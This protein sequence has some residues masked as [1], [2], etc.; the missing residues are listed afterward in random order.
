MRYA[1]HISCALFA[2]LMLNACSQIKER[3][4]TVT[5][6][7]IARVYDLYLYPADIKGLTENSSKSDSSTIVNMYIHD[8]INRN[9]MIRT[10]QENLPKELLDIE[11]KVEDYRQSLIIYNYESELINQKLDTLISEEE[12]LN[13]YKKHSDN[14][15]LDEDVYQI[16]YIKVLKQTPQLDSWMKLFKSETQEDR[17]AL[18]SYCKTSAILFSLDNTKWLSSEEIMQNL[19]IGPE[20]YSKLR[21]GKNIQRV[22]NGDMVIMTKWNN[23]KQ[24]GEVSPFESVR[25]E[26]YL[27]LLNKRK[28]DLVENIYKEIYQKAQDKKD[29]EIMKPAPEGATKK[30]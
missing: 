3:T 24:A 5:E 19:Q 9:L 16:E 29:F 21:S 20:T 11:K 4:K 17:A 14:F 25:E 1:N 6:Q 7:P 15:I 8:W 2:L 18:T 13:Y 27:I 23:V 28:S 22:D 10:A 30:K 26:I 12:K